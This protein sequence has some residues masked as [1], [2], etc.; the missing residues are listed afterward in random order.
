MIVCR[1]T[2]LA[3]SSPYPPTRSRSARPPA[4][5]CAARKRIA[6]SS[7]VRAA[8]T[9][10]A[11]S[12]AA[13]NSPH[14][15]CGIGGV[16]R[17]Q[18]AL[19]EDLLWRVFRRASAPSF[20][21]PDVRFLSLRCRGITPRLQLALRNEVLVLVLHRD[22]NLKLPLVATW[23]PRR[24]GIRAARGG[25]RRVHAERPDRPKPPGTPRQSMQV[26]VV[27]R[28]SSKRPGKVRFPMG[29]AP[30]QARAVAEYFFLR[31]APS[32]FSHRRHSTVLR[33]VATTEPSRDNSAVMQVRLE[34]AAGVEELSPTPGAFWRQS[35][36]ARVDGNGLIGLPPVD[37]GP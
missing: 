25:M 7:S 1:T 15:G 23:L 36:G 19:K 20:K 21:P 5:P 35:E 17:V 8:P 27:P 32:G 10:C 30:E 26:R 33:L 12:S 28:L 13:S 6:R 37:F 16:N 2:Q 14:F 4:P 34:H 31:R 18:I 9:N 11:A 29:S 24:R 22:A 3:A